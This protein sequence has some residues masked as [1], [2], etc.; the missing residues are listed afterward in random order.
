[1]TEGLDAGVD[2][3]IPG[4]ALKRD[5]EIRCR[6]ARSPIRYE[7]I[8]LGGAGATDIQGSWMR[9]CALR[10]DGRVSC[11]RWVAADGHDAPPRIRDVE[12]VAGARVIDYAQGRGCAIDGDGALLCWKDGSATRT[13]G[14]ERAVD[15]AVSAGGVCAIDQAGALSCGDGERVERA[16]KFP[17]SGASRVRA[18]MAV[19]GG[20]CAHF[21]EDGELLC[22]GGSR[23]PE[24]GI[25][26]STFPSGLRDVVSF[27]RL[28]CAITDRATTCWDPTENPLRPRSF[29]IAA[30][31]SRCLLTR[32]GRVSCYGAMDPCPV[33]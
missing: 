24:A 15:V 21:E 7:R 31:S 19:R 30:L 20:F 6:R 26:V 25:V 17:P 23:Y 27:G 13:R 29:P 14:I 12:G 11:W 2:E 18:V 22:F 9:G 1:M 5:G 32:D 33:F 4:C 16:E 10:T 28:D 3:I 8:D